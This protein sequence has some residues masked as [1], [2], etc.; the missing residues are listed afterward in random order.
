[1]YRQIFESSP[2]AMIV[3]RGDGTI[4]MANAC[5]DQLFGFR[6]GELVGLS[7]E[8]LMP[9]SLR[10]THRLHR[11]RYMA[12]PCMRPMGSTGMRL[13][14]QR[15]DGTEVP[16][17]IG[18]SPLPDAT[19][20][21]L[22]ASIRD[23][24]QSQR[25]RDAMVRVHYDAVASRLAQLTLES[26][27]GDILGSVPLL[28]KE[29]LQVDAVAILLRLPPADRWEVRAAI[30]LDTV[31]CDAQ[32][33]TELPHNA[34]GR[35][36]SSGAPQ[37]VNDSAATDSSQPLQDVRS[38][39]LMPL[40]D[41]GHPMGALLALSRQPRRFHHD[42]QHLLASTA[43]MLSALL[44]RHRYEEQLAHALQLDALGQLTGGIVHDFNNFLTVLSGN[45]QM[46]KEECATHPTALAIIE[47]AMRSAER[48][49]DLTLKLVAFARRQSLRPRKLDT[50]ALL[51]DA[52]MMLQPTLG[53]A[54]VL[55]LACCAELPNIYADAAQLEASLLN[56]ILNARDAM[57]RGGR[58]TLSASRVQVERS[59]GNGPAPG[60]Y[61]LISVADTGHGML[62]EISARVLEPFFTTKPT[63]RGSGLG[64]SMAYG[65]ARQ[66]GGHLS[67]A[68]RLGY[69]TRADL[70]LPCSADGLRSTRSSRSRSP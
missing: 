46:L 57:P 35:A 67:L 33:W 30:G 49:G 62:P 27:G 14:G 60:N 36:L 39:A 48:G 5:A 16:V 65:F 50:H 59:L 18:L 56:L 23:I 15:R 47:A 6:S 22:L 45:L 21:L 42:A 25:M 52:Q 12:A 34:M 8:V 58:I 69:G 43:N 51:R 7:V 68:S 64:L 53:H 17:E 20:V 70:Y 37:V 61:V 10:S 9:T 38:Y 29:T 11:Q 54:I 1:M 2:D 3:V 66:S 55:E 28:L 4:L 19:G 24:S 26:S 32:L 63:G 44:Q 40:L 31:A 41:Q 13:T